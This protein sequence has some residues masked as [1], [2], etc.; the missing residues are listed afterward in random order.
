MKT[1]T[2]SPSVDS[3]MLHLYKP[4]V[5]R[6]AIVFIA[7]AVIAQAALLF[8]D[9]RLV[10]RLSTELIGSVAGS[11]GAQLQRLISVQGNML[12]IALDEVDRVALDAEGSDAELYAKVI[13][14]L[15]TYPILDSVNIADNE[16]NEFVVIRDDDGF[17]TR[18]I[19]GANLDIAQWQRVRNDEIVEAWERSTDVRPMERPWFIG[20]LQHEP[21]S[22]FWTKPYAFLSTGEPGVSVATRWRSESDELERVIAF[23][24]SLVD[25]S[26]QTMN[27][28]PSENGMVMVLDS[29][30]RVLGLPAHERFSDDRQITA[31]TLLPVDELGI[32][33]VEQAV[34]AW[35]D[36]GGESS[37]FPFAGPLGRAWWAGF[38]RIEL[39]T[40]ASIWSVVL[41]PRKDLLGSTVALRNWTILGIILAGVAIAAL[42]LGIMMRSIR[43]QLKAEI[44]R[45]EQRLGQYLIEEKIGAGGNGSVY[46]ARH[47]LLRRPTALKL[48][49]PEFANSDAARERFEHEVRLTSGL[50]HPNTVAVY[51]FGHTA[52][53]TLY[54][55]MELLEGSTLNRLVQASG[56]AP[57]SRT[58]HFLMQAC[59]SLAEAHAKGLIHRDI[60]PSN[61]IA[62]ERGGVYDVL[63]VLDFGLVKEMAQVD[64]NLTQ[65]DVL[66]GTPFYMAPEIISQPGA[67]GPASDLYALGAV[68]YFLLTGRN[69]FEGASAVEICAAHLHDAPERPS[70]RAGR[71]VSE[72]LENVILQCLAKDPADRPANADELLDAL[73]ACADAGDWGADDARAWWR[74]YGSGVGQADAEDDVP[75]SMTGM[76]VDLESRIISP[77]KP[78]GQ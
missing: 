61:L 60:K 71:E 40:Q 64:G 5:R 28:H 3:R 26:H 48:M 11:V 52:D 78:T 42:M 32:G 73:S 21:R 30:R 9:E 63:K 43:R 70:V 25:I 27:L 39:D 55:A 2:K 16:G 41:V 65:A 54:Y 33:T 58:I 23:N 8:F 7:T 57:A 56:P 44:D 76:L 17:L 72:D 67:A 15:K 74:E 34:S 69:V 29:S 36:H 77:E 4:L 51:D 20:A 62:C 46:R 1:Q 13:P 24:L 18:R 50:S 53:G 75:M 14:F 31:T 38:N 59:G 49:N 47:A 45:V 10:R 22:R 66:I 37:I 19:A 68:G 6:L 35:D 12:L